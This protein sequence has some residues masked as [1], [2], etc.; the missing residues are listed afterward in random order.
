MSND[1]DHI[2]FTTLVHP[3]NKEDFKN[4]APSK[5]E[6]KKNLAQCGM[7]GAVIAV[8]WL[9]LKGSKSVVN[10]NSAAIAHGSAKA[11]HKK[12]CRAPRVKDEDDAETHPDLAMK[13][14]LHVPASDYLIHLFQ[15][16]AVISMSLLTEPSAVE[17]HMLQI[18]VGTLPSD[19]MGYMQAMMSGKDTSTLQ[20]MLNVQKLRP[21]PLSLT[22]A[23]RLELDEK[24]AHMRKTHP[25]ATIIPLMFTNGAKNFFHPTVLMQGAIDDARNRPP[26]QIKSTLSDITELPLNE[27]NLRE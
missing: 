4:M 27:T 21:V 2:S 10:A 26:M 5:K 15:I 16:Y 1:I 24:K 12:T 19:T 7:N 11:E 9:V 23:M 18:T 3:D 25:N 6:V 14:A 22:P 13:L 20:V 8:G 17:T